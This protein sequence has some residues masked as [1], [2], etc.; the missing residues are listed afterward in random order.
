MRLRTHIKPGLT[1]MA[2][3]ALLALTG[4]GA[5]STSTVNAAASSTN[6]AQSIDTSILRTASFKFKP[7]DTPEA[8]AAQ[9]RIAVTAIGEVE[10]FEEGL[11]YQVETGNGTTPYPR[12]NMVV[13]VNKAF[14]GAARNDLISSGRL[15]VELDRGPVSAVDGK[16][17]INSPE[18]FEKSIPPGT[19]VAV[20]LYKTTPI[21]DNS[22]EA[23][24][25]RKAAGVSTL[26]PHPQGLIFQAVSADPS[27]SRAMEGGLTSLQDMPKGW[28]EIRSMDELADRMAKVTG[29]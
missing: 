5:A 17:P 28:Q 22:T 14:K 10:G 23:Q 3:A 15:Y 6:P 11:T 19:Q 9:S 7:Y 24:T 18:D 13:K 21:S 2:T 16:T 4:C 20:F 29:D 1:A 8:L 27:V 25:S 12:V 26:T